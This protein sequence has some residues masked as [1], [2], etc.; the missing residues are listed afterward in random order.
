MLRWSVTWMWLVSA[1]AWGSSPLTLSPDSGEVDGWPAVTAWADAQ[2][3]VDA[4]QAMARLGE[5]HRPQVPHANFGVRRDVVWLHLPLQVAPNDDGKWL[6]SVDY[7][8]LNEALVTVWH[9]GRQVASARLGNGQPFSA[10]PQL[11]R[12]HAM[13]LALTPGQRYDVLL[14]LRSSSSV[15]APITLHKEEAFHAREARMQLMLGLWFGIALALVAYSFAHWLSLRDRLFAYYG[16]AILGT[17]TFFFVFSGLGNQHVWDVQNVGVL[18]KIAPMGILLAL[19]AGALF[20]TR[21]LHTEQRSPRTHKGLLGL[22]T[23]G[24][25]SLVATAVGLF[26]YR[27]AHTASIILGPA[28]ILLALPAA[29]RSSR[30]GQRV[31]SWMLAGWLCYLVGVLTLAL[32]LRGLVPAYTW[33][34]NL[35]Q[36]TAMVEMLVWLRVLGLHIEV[37]RHAAEHATA[38]REVLESLAHTDALTGLPNRRGLM[39][40]LGQARQGQLALYLL[41]LDGFKP[42]NDGHGHD[43]GDALLV[44]VAQRLQ[45]ELRRSDLVSRLGGDEF[46]V[47]ACRMPGPA[48][49]EALGAKL[50]SAFDEPFDVM[51]QRCV[52]GATIGYALAPHDGSDGEALLKAAD[53]AMYAGKAAGRRTVRRAEPQPNPPC[54]TSTVGQRLTLR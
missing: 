21:A 25:V 42:V 34:I 20:V 54:E 11:S 13:R 47:L 30:A 28:T 8:P 15:I 36:L 10:R 17:S 9:Q 50:L 31:G 53:I 39:R 48:E 35:F 29:W 14:R 32:L 5:F 12:T 49:A 37:V 51:G 18:A 33:T 27:A 22:A 23:F 16:T 52:L 19:V 43:V 7:P 41:D 6:L 26:D 44:A 1:P 4:P 38:E 3:Q 24:A 45:G 46:V 2:G 40:A